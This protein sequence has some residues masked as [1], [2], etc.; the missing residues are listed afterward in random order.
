MVNNTCVIIPCAGKGTRLNIPFPKEL[1]PVEYG[2]V[3]IDYSFD[4]LKSFGKV[5]VVII[6][7]PEKVEIMR[8][9]QKYSDDFDIVFCYQK[10]GSKGMIGAI[11]SAKD[12]F[13]ENN[14]LLLPDTIIQSS[15]KDLIDMTIEYLNSFPAVFWAKKE[16]DY[17]ILSREGALRLIKQNGHLIVE[18][19]IDKPGKNSNDLNGYW[20]ACAFQ[21][22]Y[23]TDFLEVMDNAIQKQV[24]FSFKESFLSGSPAIE[25]DSS[26]DMG[27]WESICQ[28]MGR[29]SV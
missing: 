1:M 25:V 22:K 6:I 18:D 15:Q 24:G 16:N 19:Y 8:Y 10:T 14:L 3:L 4:L 5:R 7:N 12:L 9:L 28:Y 29:N 2:Q 13:L 17:E 11:R 21:R 20:A 26:I 23:S 27:V